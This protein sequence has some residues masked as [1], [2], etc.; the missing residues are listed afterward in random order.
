MDKYR[1]EQKDKK[2]AKM[3]KEQKFIRKMKGFDKRDSRRKE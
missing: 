1:Q 2:K 3:K